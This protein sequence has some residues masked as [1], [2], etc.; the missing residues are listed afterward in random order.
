MDIIEA[1]EYEAGDGVGADGPGGEGEHEGVEDYGPDGESNMLEE[2]AT[3]KY[4]WFFV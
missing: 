1:S 3:G 2:Q 4:N